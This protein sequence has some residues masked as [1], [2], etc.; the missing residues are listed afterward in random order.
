M[1]VNFYAKLRENVGQKCVDFHIGEG[2]TVG[3]LMNDMIRQFPEL[4]SELL[5]DQG[6]LLQH[7]HFFVNG[8]DLE[9]LPHGK[10]TEISE[11]DTISVFPAVGGG[12]ATRDLSCNSREVRGITLWLIRDYLYE[13][14]GHSEED[15]YIIGEGW[16]AIL[17]PMESYQLGSLVVGQV[18]LKIEAPSNILEGI[19][20]LLEK[21]L[22]RCG[23]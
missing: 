23:G 22:L 21:K 18:F 8:R 15:G 16:R 4:E 7:V 14:G 11:E 10:E 6:E 17:K 19:L 13:L 5:D 1:K 9:Y 20:P 2:A 3:D 12:I